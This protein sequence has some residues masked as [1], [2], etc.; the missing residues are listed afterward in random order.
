[1]KD[2]F[3]LILQKHPQARF[4]IAGQRPVAKV[5]ALVADNV[6]VT[7]F[8]EDFA[9]MYNSAAVVVAPLRFGAGTQNKVLEAMAM[10]IPVITSHVGFKGLNINSG[11][12]A[13]MK[14]D[15][16]SFADAVIELL[17][18]A[19][20]RRSVGEKGVEVIR[21]QFSWDIISRRLESYFEHL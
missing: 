1:V 13:I 9:A 10:G 15:A 6:I 19:A 5:K 3:P 7:G 4:I 21:S 20:L 18:N 14:T 11:E 16:T 8:V 12:G 2:I 17:T